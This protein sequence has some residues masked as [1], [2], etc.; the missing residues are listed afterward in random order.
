MGTFGG[1]QIVSDGLIMH[2]DSANPHSY[3]GSGTAINDLS[4]NSINGT[5]KNGPVFNSGNAGHIAFDGTNDYIILPVA[6]VLSVNYH[7]ISSWNYSTEFNQYGFMFEKTSNGLVNT[8]YSLFLNASNQLYY[9]TYGLSN[10][11]T[12]LS[13][14]ANY[15]N[16]MW[17]NTVATYDGSNKKIYI[18]GVLKLTTAATGTVTQA[19]TGTSI[20]GAYGSGTGY[21]FNGKIAQTSVYS[22]ALTAAEVLQNYNATKTRFI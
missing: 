7:T 20:I 11:S 22:R 13:I 3:P 4:G 17:T 19:T 12:T 1:P 8:Q 21:L 5:L 16:S 14:S 9:R 2:I 10:V 18:N 6:S 15:T